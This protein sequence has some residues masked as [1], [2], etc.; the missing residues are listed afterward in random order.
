M[1]CTSCG[2]Q[3]PVGARFC[4]KC[5]NQII[6][7]PKSTV[8][9]GSPHTT[10]PSHSPFDPQLAAY[11]VLRRLICRRP[12]F[13]GL[14]TERDSIPDDLKSEVEFGCLVYQIA[15]YLDLIKETLGHVASERVRTHL[16]LLAGFDPELEAGIVR[17]LDAVRAGDAEFKAGL[18]SDL[19]EGPARD[20]NR[21][22]AALAIL[23]LIAGG[24]PEQNQKA[25]AGSVGEC[26][27]AARFQADDVFE[28]EVKSAG[29][30]STAFRWSLEPGPFERQLQ[31]QH[32][33]PLFP[34]AVRM[35]SAQQVTDARL[36]DL[37]R[38][39][40]FIS[41]YR[42]IEREVLP[43]RT[44]MVVKEASDMEKRM[45]DLIPSCMTL[46]DYFSKEEKFLID[47]SDSIDQ[48]LT[49]ATKEPSL[50]DT[51]KRYM[52][53]TRIQGYLLT[54]GVALPTGEGTEDYGLRSILSEEPELIS[55]YAKL[56]KNT[57]VFGAD[58]LDSAQ[59]V[60]NEAVRE[61]MDSAVGKRKLDAFRSG[62]E[63]VE[64]KSESGIWA[65]VKRFVRRS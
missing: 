24:C 11:N 42:T 25:L 20:L 3:N 35:I 18:F 38:M 6:D 13:A 1:Y 12:P 59:E 26:L 10:E 61:G 28:R 46:G 49:R 15:V 22:Y 36:A 65:G 16:I 29:E 53:L 9:D 64:S 32:N 44:K 50:R 30:I 58:P 52:A 43:A 19:F 54:I 41:T 2:F 23:F 63:A 34:R 37:K 17:Y 45:I 31:R 56:G 48:E 51:Y 5:G 8:E 39:S 47:V 21:Y 60:I 62:W 57:G 7:L 33:N 14:S 55:S 40:D 27:L 4:P